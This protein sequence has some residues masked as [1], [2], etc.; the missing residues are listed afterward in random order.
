M[1]MDARVDVDVSRPIGT[2]SPNLYGSFAEHLGRCIY[3]GIWVGPD[4]SIPN[5]DGIRLDVAEALRELGLPVLRWPGGCFADNYHWQ[6]GVGPVEKRKR[7]HNLWWSQ[8]EPNQF[9]TGEFMRLCQL[10]G[11]QPYICLNVGSGSVEE[12]IGWVEYCNSVQDTYYTR[13]RRQSG[14]AEAYGVRFWGIG[15]ENWG[16]GGSMTPEHYAHE[17][18]KY[19]TYVRRMDDTVDGGLFLI[20]AGH[21]DAWNFRFLRQM[22]GAMHLVDGLSIH[23]YVGGYS[24]SATEFSDEEY[25][26]LM[27][28]VLDMEAAVRR[29]D[30]LLSDLS[31]TRHLW[32]VVDEWGTWYPEAT[33]ATGLYQQNA[34][35]DAVF[36]A[37]A[38]NMFNR[39]CR[40][41]AMTNMAQTVNVLQSV[42]LTRG[43]D[44]VRTPTYWTYHMF[45]PH[46]GAEAV[47]CS[48]ACPRV[49]DGQG[50]LVPVV[51]ASAS[52]SPDGSE[53]AVTLANIHL[54][55]AVELAVV[56]F[57]GAG[58]AAEGRLLTADS[59]RAHNTFEQPERVVPRPL[60]VSSDGNEV[61]V[62][63]PPAS[64]AAIVMHA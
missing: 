63:L 57:G 36:A 25:Y 64:V 5:A 12:A 37:C 19:A 21:T 39:Y 30:I 14:R 3:G 45:R 7:R 60:D 48:V 10:V 18:R 49:C 24:K 56:V 51:S 2:I 26:R 58:R 31:P 8:P 4:S 32:L 33:V 46:M 13:L 22:Q 29:A 27:G 43:P 6:W 28:D 16:C 38:L 41:V 62:T 54:E 35:R 1:R 34:L 59:A 9:G 52:R 61:T 50:R 44:M 53:I 17:Y 23:L 40:R 47:E 55:Q 42:I 15:N 20:A 11:C